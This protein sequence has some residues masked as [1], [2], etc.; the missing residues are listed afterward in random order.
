M[1]VLVVF[2]SFTPDISCLS[3]FSLFFRFKGA[4]VLIYFKFFSFP[5]GILF[6]YIL[7]D[8]IGLYSSCYMTFNNSSRQDS[9]PG[10]D[11]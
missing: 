7:I 11:R 3:L 4:L 10:V 5:L 1:V 6:N 9:L 8:S 2:G